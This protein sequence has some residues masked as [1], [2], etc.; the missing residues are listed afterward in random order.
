M[1]GGYAP[2][3]RATALADA[4][5][6]RALKSR[7][8]AA[9]GPV[10]AAMS[11]WEG[12]AQ[13]GEATIAALMSKKVNKLAEADHERMLNA[14]DAMI[15]QLAGEKA[16]RR[17]NEQGQSVGGPVEMPTDLEGRPMMLSDKA[18]QLS[19]AMAGM[20]PKQGNQVLSGAMLQKALVDP[21]QEEAYTLTP[22]AARFKGG[23]QIAAMPT[24]AKQP[25]LPDGMRINPQTGQPEWIPG[26]LEAKERLAAAGRSTTNVTFDPDGSNR[27]GPPPAGYY[28]PDPSQ[29]GITMMPGG[30]Q[31]RE[32]TSAEEKEQA[33]RESSVIKRR[34]RWG[35]RQSDRADPE[36]YGWFLGRC[37][38]K[39]L[40]I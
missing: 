11:P 40:A 20:D 4:L 8:P 1:T 37:N 9:G 38:S 6:V 33:R 2:Q 32:A 15:R 26:Y 5:T 12:V 18:E 7:T 17:M 39:R 22:G 19:A 16:P 21:A 23:K 35:D 34:R 14:N 28:R 36:G 3:D 25:N 24:D 29:P 10:Q 30:P 13:L 31:Q 27:F